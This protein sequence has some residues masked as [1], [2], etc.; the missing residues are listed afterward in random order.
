MASRTP[1]GLILFCTS[2]T[3]LAAQPPAATGNPQPP[4]PA[5]AASATLP[6]A[7]LQPSLDVLRSALPGLHVDRWRASNAIRDEAQSNLGSI[8]RDVQTTLP[9]LL[10]AADAAPGSAGKVLPVYRNVEALYDV[11]LRVDAAA[12]LAAPNDQM[13]AIDQA[14]ARLDDG[15]RA[16]GDQLQQAT[17]GQEKQVLHLQAALKAI[18]PPQPPPPPPAPV[19]CPVAPVRKRRPTT[20]AA[21]PSTPPASQNSNSS[22]PSH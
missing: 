20:T 5:P 12:R 15:R 16:L 2:A 1:L 3:L 6:S 4:N 14:L 9:A 21:K 18:P 8:Q 11:M 7:T 17:D 19:K 22:T 13:S 10:A